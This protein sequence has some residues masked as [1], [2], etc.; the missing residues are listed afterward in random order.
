MLKGHIF[1]ELV[2]CDRSAGRLDCGAPNALEATG[3][4]QMLAKHLNL[5]R[6]LLGDPQWWYVLLVSLQIHQTG[7]PS[8]E[9]GRPGPGCRFFEDD[10]RKS[11]LGRAPFGF[12]VRRRGD[13]N[14]DSS[15]AWFSIH[16]G[17]RL[18][19]RMVGKLKGNQKEPGAHFG[20]PFF[21]KSKL[22]TLKQW[23]FSSK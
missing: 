18:K 13:P 16:I 19:V 11:L 9:D 17:P 21:R 20:G 5:V 7:V 3:M 15:R 1:W 6:L 14:G 12:F 4:L 10:T 23:S 2:G 8:K 22:G